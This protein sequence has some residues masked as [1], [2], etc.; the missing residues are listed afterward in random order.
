MQDKNPLAPRGINPTSADIARQV[1]YRTAPDYEAE[2]GIITYY[3]DHCV[4]V[5]YGNAVNS[6]ATSRCDLDWL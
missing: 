6:K 5:R 2:E 3:N 1:V 4:F